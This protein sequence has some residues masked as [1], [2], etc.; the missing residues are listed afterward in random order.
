[1]GILLICACGRQFPDG[2]ESLPAARCPDCG[3]ALMSLDARPAPEFGEPAG[4]DLILYPASSGKATASLVLGLLS[5]LC[6]AFAGL[7]AILLGL[8]GLIEVSRSGGRIAGRRMAISGIALGMFGSTVVMFAVMLP[9]FRTVREVKRRADCA[10][11]LKQIA[12][13]MFKF[14][15]AHGA[16][17]AAAIT[18]EQGRP[19]LSWR[20][21]I[22]PY[23]GPEAEALYSEFHLDEAWDSPHN[24]PLLDRM[25]EVYACPD[26]QPQGKPTTTNYLVSVGPSKLFTGKPKGVKLQNWAAGTSRTLMVTESDQSVPWTAPREISTGAGPE[27]GP[28]APDAGSRHPGGYHVVM[29]D[30]SVRY[31]RQIKFGNAPAPTPPP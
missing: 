31:T 8:L 11:N 19:L 14:E 30:G 12:L 4:L 13:A 9:A 16:F 24:R 5:L 29:A 7:P 17:P 1:M 6:A 23:L 25:P 10:E 28:R 22:L 18:D 27:T 26:E 3:R 2:E 15:D 20:V 21:A